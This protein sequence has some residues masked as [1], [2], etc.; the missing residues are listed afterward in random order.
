MGWLIGQIGQTRTKI[1]T[2]QLG[3]IVDLASLKRSTCRDTMPVVGAFSTAGSHSVEGKIQGVSPI[4]SDR[5]LTSLNGVM[6]TSD[7][8]TDTITDL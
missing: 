3:K 6:G 7:A 5:C 8:A 1:G 4:T 2:R